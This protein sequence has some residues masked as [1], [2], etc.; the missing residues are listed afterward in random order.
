MFAQLRNVILFTLITITRL[1]NTVEISKRHLIVSSVRVMWFIEY[2]LNII[3][4]NLILLN[5]LATFG[6]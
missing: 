2:F 1:E 6:K 5:T 3:R 4:I